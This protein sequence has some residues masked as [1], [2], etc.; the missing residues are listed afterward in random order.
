METNCMPKVFIQLCGNNYFS[1]GTEKE[2]MV[3]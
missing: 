1:M 2:N 3:L